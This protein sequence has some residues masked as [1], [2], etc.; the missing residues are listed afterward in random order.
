MGGGGLTVD[1]TA[2]IFGSVL[3]AD[4]RAD[5]TKIKQIVSTFEMKVL[6]T[7]DGRTILEWTLNQCGELG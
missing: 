6:R 4:T 2:T 3:K 1:Q 5:S 7:V